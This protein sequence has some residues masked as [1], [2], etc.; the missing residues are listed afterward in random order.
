MPSTSIPEI[1]IQ[2]TDAPVEVPIKFEADVN[3]FL[4]EHMKGRGDI[5]HTVNW[6]VKL[7]RDALPPGRRGGLEAKAG[8]DNKQSGSKG[9]V[10]E[11][12]KAANQ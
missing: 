6:I 7:Y 12:K 10:S 8:Q 9:T 5:H 4:T 11:L 1:P 3:S 2:N